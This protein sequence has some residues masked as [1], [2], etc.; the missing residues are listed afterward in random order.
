MEFYKQL[1]AA[2]LACASPAE[3][4]L[5]SSVF[6]AQEKSAYKCLRLKPMFVKETRLPDEPSMQRV[7]EGTSRGL[8]VRPAVSGSLGCLRLSRG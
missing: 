4:A 2:Q 1:S 7:P 8:V 5:T 3:T 6:R